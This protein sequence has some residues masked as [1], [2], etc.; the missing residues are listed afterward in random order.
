MRIHRRF[1]DPARWRHFLQDVRPDS[2]AHL[3]LTEQLNR[4][5]AMRL[6]AEHDWL[7]ALKTAADARRHQSRR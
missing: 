4:A 1:A 5:D 6:A 2:W 3:I 7:G